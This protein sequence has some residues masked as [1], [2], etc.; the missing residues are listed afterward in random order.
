MDRSAFMGDFRAEATEH[1]RVLDAEL[2]K[3]ERNA[4]DPEPIRRMFLSAHTIKGGASMLALGEIQNVAH[5]MEDVLSSLRDNRLPL[6]PATADLLF[7]AIDLLRELVEQGAEP[8]T[9]LC[10]QAAAL[11]SALREPAGDPEASGDGVAEPPASVDRPRVLIAEASRT[12]GLLASMLLSDAGF[13]VDVVEDGEVA[14]Q[15]ALT[16]SYDLLVSGIELPG[17][18]GLD[19]VEALR[20][21][22]SGGT[23]PVV[24]VT[25]EENPVDRARAASLQVQAYVRKGSLAD[26]QLVAAA[27]EATR[28]RRS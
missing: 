21:H 3:L 23:L 6:A 26:G 4:A 8:S 16:A 24:L 1:L 25:T 2:L 22:P 15:Q 11:A 7:Q 19:L 17:R 27:Q 18:R 20:N 12:A 28:R 13:V 10:H 9:D 5:A 14:L